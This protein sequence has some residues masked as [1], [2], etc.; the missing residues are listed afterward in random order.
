MTPKYR[1]VSQK[2]TSNQPAAGP[3]VPRR[4]G[5]E[6]NFKQGRSRRCGPGFF[7]LTVAVFAVIAVGVIA[8]VVVVAVAAAGARDEVED[9]PG[10]GGPGFVEH[11][12]GPE[13][14]VAGR[15][16]GTDDQAKG[17]HAVQNKQG[18]ADGMHR[19]RIDND[20]LEM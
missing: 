6:S 8:V 13:D 15:L 4:L 2:S 11:L 20:A 18:V 17:L 10:Q 9:D 12:H 16:A 1:G 14:G 19:R 5:C 7:L 3:R